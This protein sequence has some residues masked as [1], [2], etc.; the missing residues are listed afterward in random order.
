MNVLQVAYTK[1]KTTS[2]GCSVSDKHII[3][4]LHMKLSR[5]QPEECYD[6][7]STKK[8]HHQ[9]LAQDVTEPLVMTHPFTYLNKICYFIS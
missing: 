1:L 6:C 2:I 5:N 9:V 4:E 7:F 8:P 3:V